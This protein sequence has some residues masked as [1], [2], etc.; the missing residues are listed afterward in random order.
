MCLFLVMLWIK[1]CH[2]SSGEIF[3]YH[4]EYFPHAENLEL[5]SS[6]A[7]VNKII[8]GNIIPII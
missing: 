3:P 2:N 4:C 7:F 1:K 8:R 5:F 6:S